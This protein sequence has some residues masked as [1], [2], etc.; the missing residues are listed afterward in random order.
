ML[1]SALI[2]CPL[3]L[4]STAER[5]PGAAEQTDPQLPAHLQDAS[6]LRLV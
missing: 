1:D 4:H 2:A 5:F 3:F 6:T